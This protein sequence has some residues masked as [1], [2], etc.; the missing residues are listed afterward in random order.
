MAHMAPLSSRGVA[1]SGRNGCAQVRGPLMSALCGH[2][3]APRV[4]GGLQRVREEWR[5]IKAVQLSL[6]Q[7]LLYTCRPDRGLKGR[8]PQRDG[9][10]RNRQ[11]PH[12]HLCGIPESHLPHLRMA[13]APGEPPEPGAWC[14]RLGEQF[15][16]KTMAS[17]EGSKQLSP[18]T[19]ALFCWGAGLHA[20]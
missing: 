16:W 17:E 5:G 10:Q 18:W 19:S 6:G 4:C 2:P 15:R 9:G 1:L 12:G 14:L 13:W 11:R 7:P 20:G 3:T 8:G